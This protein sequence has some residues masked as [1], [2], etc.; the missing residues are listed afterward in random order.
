MSNRLKRCNDGFA[1]GLCVVPGCEHAEQA[2]RRIRRRVRLEVPRAV[3]ITTASAPAVPAPQEPEPHT[4][5]CAAPSPPS[6]RL[7]IVA[8]IVDLVAEFYQIDR[9]AI[10]GKDRH[11]SLAEA[12]VVCCWLARTQVMPTPSFP[13]LAR[14]MGNRDHTT[15]MSAVRRVEVLRQRDQWLASTITRLAAQV[16]AMQGPGVAKAEPQV[17]LDGFE[18][19]RFG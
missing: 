9:E 16:K 6:P 17:E 15:I 7:A 19:G 2:R 1:P 8:R 13:E 3:E 10:L 4:S 18:S 14:A 5:P 11:K 12:R